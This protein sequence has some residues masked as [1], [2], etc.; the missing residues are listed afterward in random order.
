MSRRH[1]G[2]R[3]QRLRP[4]GPGAAMDR[5]TSLPMSLPRRRAS[6]DQSDGCDVHAYARL[7]LRASFDRLRTSGN[8]DEV[9][10]TSA[11]R[12]CYGDEIAALRSQ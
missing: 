9:E 10:H 2:W 6:G 8:L 11:N 1:G 7:S 12:R 4:F 3:W 5:R